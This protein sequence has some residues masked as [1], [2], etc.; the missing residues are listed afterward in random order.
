MIK[1]NRQICISFNS[2]GTFDD[3]PRIAATS[4]LATVHFNDRI[5]S[6]Y[7]ERHPIAQDLLSLPQLLVIHLGE[8]VNLDFMLSNFV[9]N[10][11]GRNDEKKKTTNK[12]TLKKS[13][14]PQCKNT[15]KKKD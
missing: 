15:K 14:S 13:T 1:I 8:L 4:N 12:Q 5:R 9:E 2:F 10:L 6:D 3:T 11:T 7:G